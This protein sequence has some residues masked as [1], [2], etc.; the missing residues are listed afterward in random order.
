[1]YV[2]ILS[3]FQAEKVLL[4]SLYNDDCCK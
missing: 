4:K 2:S 1:M 3:G